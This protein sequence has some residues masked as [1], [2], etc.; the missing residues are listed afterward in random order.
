VPFPDLSDPRLSQ[1][2]DVKD[3]ERFPRDRRTLRWRGEYV[4]VAA[5]IAFAIA[6]YFFGR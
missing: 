1:I 5:C 4:V 6:A 3:L 2:K